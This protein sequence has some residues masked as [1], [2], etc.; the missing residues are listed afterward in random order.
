[1]I[2]LVL[3]TSSITLF[4]YIANEFRSYYL[5]TP[6]KVFAKT[7]CPLYEK[8]EPGEEA[9]RRASNKKNSKIQFILRRDFVPTFWAFNGHLQTWL[10]TLLS[11]QES[12][13]I[14]YSREYLQMED[15]GIVSLDWVSMVDSE[16]SSSSQGGGGAKIPGA[17]PRRRS[18]KKKSILVKERPVLLIIPNALNA[19]VKDYTDLCVMAINKGFKPI[20]F[21]RRG[22][23]RTIL[24]TSKVTTYNDPS[25]LR[26]TLKYLNALFPFVG[27]VFAVAF[28]MESGNLI[29]YLGSEGDESLIAG[30]VCVSATFGCESQLEEHAI[31]QPYNVII[32]EKIKTMFQSNAPSSPYEMFHSS[33]DETKLFDNEAVQKCHTMAALQ[34]EIHARCNDYKTLQ[35]YL[36]YNNPLTHL[37]R[38]QVPVLFIHSND[39]PIVPEAAVPYEFFGITDWCILLT[40]EQGGHCGFFEG[41]LTPSSWADKQAVDFLKFIRKKWKKSQPSN[42]NNFYPGPRARSMTVL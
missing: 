41:G 5:T 11:F 15:N 6:I 42:N 30:A 17:G 32:T 2:E 19:N 22:Y 21:N 1:M 20:F 3:L 13:R 28:S 34:N 14:A 33:E 18:L 35:D 37:R 8:L 24:S 26:E 12:P 23:S 9:Q 10:K 31:Q 39:D 27:G 40:T 38:I 29:S 25:D 36:N 7:T 16:T 4:L